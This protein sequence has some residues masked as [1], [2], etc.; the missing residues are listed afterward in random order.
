V[1]VELAV[2]EKADA[3]IVCSEAG[4]QIDVNDTHSSS[5]RDS[6]RFNFDPGSNA[7]DESELHCR[8]DASPRNS[9]EAGIQI[10]LSDEQ[11]ENA[12]SPIRASFDPDSNVND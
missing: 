6:I 12:C 10:D 2:P 11:D 9:T 7:N 4:R 1:I 8:K 3:S 5:A